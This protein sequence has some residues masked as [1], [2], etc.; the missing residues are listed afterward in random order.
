MNE[1]ACVRIYNQ[2]HIRAHW[3]ARQSGTMTPWHR[4]YV[5]VCASIC[6]RLCE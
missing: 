3:Q 2:T 5:C 6:V 1:I 4:V